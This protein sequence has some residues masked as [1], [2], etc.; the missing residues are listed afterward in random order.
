MCP[1]F[2]IVGSCPGIA[3]GL[4]AVC[5]ENP[6]LDSIILIVKWNASATACITS[7]S[8]YVPCCD[9]LA[10][11]LAHESPVILSMNLSGLALTY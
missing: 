9:I 7:T 2:I 6:R 3:T 11:Y 1:I 10:K 4:I 5:G 8:A